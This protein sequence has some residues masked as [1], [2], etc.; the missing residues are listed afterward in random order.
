MGCRK[1]GGCHGVPLHYT[2]Y[3]E[4]FAERERLPLIGR[5][6]ADAV[7]AARHVEHAIIDDL[8]EGLAVVNQ[9]RDIVGPH[10]QH[11]LR[12][13]DLAVR[14]VSE[15]RIEETRVM[16]AQFSASRLV[17]HH[18]CRI[19][20]RNADAFFGSQNVELFRL[21][22]QAVLAMPVQG[23]P[24]IR[25][26]VI[27]DFGKVDDV[28]VLFRPVA[29]DGVAGSLLSLEI[30]AKEQTV[31]GTEFLGRHGLAFGR[32]VIEQR[33]LPVQ[34]LERRVGGGGLA[35]DETD[36]VEALAGLHLDRERTG[37]DLEKQGAVIAGT[38]L[39]ESGVE[40]GD[41]AR[42]H[43]E[44]AGGAL[45]VG[46]RPQRLRQL[47][48]FQQRHE[49]NMAFLE[50]R[51]TAQVHFVHHEV[52]VIK[53][54]HVEPAGNGRQLGQKAA[55]QPI[56]FLAEAEVEAG[57][58]DLPVFDRNGGGDASSG[59]QSGDLLIGQDALSRSGSHQSSM[60]PPQ[61]LPQA[62]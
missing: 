46:P 41:D 48:G 53:V 37:Y 9:E 62:A 1:I 20:R 38:D 49:V 40:I 3:L 17:G 55:D 61:L 31:I 34:A 19:V 39:V 44:P 26:R 47:E 59:D 27:A 45:R 54:H 29:D 56:G 10:L 14:P 43:V 24:E 42:E 13:G 11:H 52:G 33:L 30:D 50:D 8:E 35:A 57:R 23:L 4:M 51:A 25:C 15:S 7:Q 18:F 12:A 32:V 5:A 22:Q 58:L 21:Q 16:G 36:L 28:A 6:Q 60:S 2:L